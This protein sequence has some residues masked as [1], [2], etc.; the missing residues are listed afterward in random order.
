MIDYDSEQADSQEEEKISEN[1]GV[2]EQEK[3]SVEF[4]SL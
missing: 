1:A 3:G 2:I 4:N